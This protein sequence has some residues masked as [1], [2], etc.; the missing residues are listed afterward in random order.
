MLTFFQDVLKAFGIDEKLGLAAF[1]MMNQQFICAEEPRNFVLRVVHESRTR[2]YG[3]VV[4]V[5]CTF[6]KLLI[7]YNSR[8]KSTDLERNTKICEKFPLSLNI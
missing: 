6:K 7:S 3:E 2:R 8:F 1:N 4:R 5:S